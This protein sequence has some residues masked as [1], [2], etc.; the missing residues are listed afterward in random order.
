VPPL[1]LGIMVD[2]VVK[3][4]HLHK[5]VT[6][7][8]HCVVQ[9]ELLE[10][11]Q[12][13]SDISGNVL[14]AWI[15]DIEDGAAL[16]VLLSTSLVPVI[17]SDS[18]EYQPGT[19]EHKAWSRR[20]AV[21][22][23]RLSGE[24]NVPRT[25]RASSVWILAASTGGPAAV[26]EF[27]SHLQPGLNIAFVYVQ[28]IDANYVATL[29][30][31]MSTAGHYPA[32]LA[33]QGA[34]LQRNA[35]A[36]INAEQSLEIVEDGTLLATGKPWGG[37]Y[38]PSIDQ[39]A[40]NIARIYRQGA[41]L[42]VFSGMGDDGARSCRLIRQQSGQVWIQTPASCT[43][44]SMPEAALAT[45]CVDFSG[46]P[47]ELACHLASFSRELSSKNQPEGKRS[48]ESSTTNRQ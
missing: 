23:L 36:L 13:N 24:I 33:G 43:S 34:V 9:D 39:V 48:H 12:K 30:K 45:N 15:V 21:R 26:K 35:I 38:A 14:D 6:E 40:A 29:I 1:R 27:L 20:M 18:S 47:K 41:G 46:T 4:Q 5:L 10:A 16:D 2:A 3:Q 28:H 22:L 17:L 32:F 8:G 31:M 44:A 37:P 7:A 11:S 25:E 42:I 19:D